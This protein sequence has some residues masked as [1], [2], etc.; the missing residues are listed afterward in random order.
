MQTRKR[1][2][3]SETRG[4]TDDAD[5][6]QFRDDD[7]KDDN[8]DDEYD[9]DDISISAKRTMHVAENAQPQAPTNTVFA[10]DWAPHNA[11][12]PA[13]EA[14]KDAMKQFLFPAFC[15]LSQERGIPLHDVCIVDGTA[16]TKSLLKMHAATFTNK[17][18][19]PTNP[20]TRSPIAD[21]VLCDV[22]GFALNDFR[23]YRIKNAQKNE[24][25][26]QQTLQQ[27]LSAA[28]FITE[29][30]RELDTFLEM[31]LRALVEDQF[32]DAY[33]S[34]FNSIIERQ[35]IERLINAYETAARDLEHNTDD[36]RQRA[37]AAAPLALLDRL[38]NIL[39]LSADLSVHV[40]DL[41]GD[42]LFNYD[43][44]LTKAVD[45]HTWRIAFVL[46][47]CDADVE[48]NEVVHCALRHALQCGPTQLV[49]K[50]LVQCH[51]RVRAFAAT[52]SSEETVCGIC[53]PYECHSTYNLT[54]AVQN[55]FTFYS[56]LG[57]LTEDTMSSIFVQYLGE[58]NAIPHHLYEA[59][60]TIFTQHADHIFASKDSTMLDK[61]FAD[62]I[63]NL[64]KPGA[65]V[66]CRAIFSAAVRL[67]RIHEIDAPGTWPLLCTIIA[68]ETAPHTTA[69]KSTFN[70]A[71][72]QSD[73][74]S[75]EIVTFIVDGT[76]EFQPNTVRKC[77][78]WRKLS[79]ACAHRRI[80]AT[81]DE[82]AFDVMYRH[83]RKYRRL[84]ADSLAN[85]RETPTSCAGWWSKTL[86]SVVKKDYA[87]FRDT[88]R[89][90]I[91]RT[92]RFYTGQFDAVVEHNNSA[93]VKY[94]FS[95]TSTVD[96]RCA[97]A[98]PAIYKLLRHT[99]MV[100]SK[101]GRFHVLSEQS[102]NNVK[103]MLTFGVFMK[104]ARLLTLIVRDVLCVAVGGRFDD[105]HVDAAG[106]TIVTPLT[107]S[108]CQE[109][110]YR[111]AV[112]EHN[113][114]LQYLLGLLGVSLSCEDPFFDLGLAARLAK[115]AV[116]G[117]MSMATTNTYVDLFLEK[118]RRAFLA[119]YPTQAEDQLAWKQQ[120]LSA[121]HGLLYS[122]MYASA[123]AKVRFLFERRLACS[124]SL[125][126]PTE[127]N[128]W[129]NLLGNAASKPLRHW[130]LLADIQVTLERWF[131]ILFMLPA[132]DNGAFQSWMRHFQQA[133]ADSSAISK[134]ATDAMCRNQ[135]RRACRIGNVDMLNRLVGLMPALGHN[136]IE[137]LFPAALQPECPERST[138]MFLTVQKMWL[139]HR[140]RR[141]SAKKN[142]GLFGNTLLRAIHC[143]LPQVVAHI[144]NMEKEW[145]SG[146]LP[147]DVAYRLI[148]DAALRCVEACK[149]A[150]LEQLIA[151]ERFWKAHA[152][153]GD[154]RNQLHT[155]MLAC[156]SCAAVFS[157][158]EAEVLAHI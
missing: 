105:Q 18:D 64:D 152:H 101:R 14:A 77:R 57:C 88:G 9:D 100:L 82:C 34:V 68:H 72:R 132:T 115:V 150:C 23:A 58:P 122:A 130:L 157:A 109:V 16:Y 91:S 41:L 94:L 65:L 140:E 22:L 87:Q 40:L 151:S 27:D 133:Y 124:P 50:L 144:L 10:T 15:P 4:S 85:L 46:L 78:F 145:V 76:R 80:A 38:F 102:P 128:L 90:D 19:M 111:A 11:L 1:K 59:A 83:F 44:L 92:L 158:K 108:V 137:Q 53:Q 155:T 52:C 25:E 96:Y 103:N 35:S 135:L 126:A 69:S 134:T 24:I 112:L 117:R 74:F 13:S 56:A 31:T 156:P 79:A 33:M 104:S 118:K 7:E 3:R 48:D 106:N 153:S 123:E 73:R 95:C 61:V 120:K 136:D 62:V 29:H 148:Q 98:E 51:D 30:N 116:T 75:C 67:G 42:N 131:D 2:T 113:G 54:V 84:C 107:A 21:S 149:P 70:S 147:I 81:S 5:N 45:C 125:S 114:I 93:V 32:N 146:L 110:V 154:F 71:E 26:V 60:A 129:R 20:M 47:T 138:I 8:D 121:I 6:V 141:P 43:T 55:V 119:E 139:D 36:D 66:F 28:Q 17:S 97:E 127:F 89:F 99:L 39:D 12:D 37:V 142:F 63:N 143:N 86:G 49:N